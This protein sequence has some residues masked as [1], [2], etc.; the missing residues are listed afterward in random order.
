MK[1]PYTMALPMFAGMAIGA[2]AIQ[3]LHAQA[4]RPVYMIAVN[5]VTNAEGYV[6][7]YVPPAQASLKAHG[8]TYVAEGLVTVIDGSL[9]GKRAIV[10]RWD[11]LDQVK[12]WFGSPE[13]RMARVAGDKYAKFNI[14]VVDGV[15]Q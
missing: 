5:E 6:R 10:V 8:G 4:Q 7:E 2:V 11:S 12:A 9:P 14:V 1:K 15:K 13:Y 3:A